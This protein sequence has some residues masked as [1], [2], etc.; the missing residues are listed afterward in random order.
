MARKHCTALLALSLLIAGVAGQAAVTKESVQEFVNDVSNKV[1]A[2]KLVSPP[3]AQTMLDQISLSVNSIATA[4]WEIDWAS[5]QSQWDTLVQAANTVVLQIQ[6]I[7]PSIPENS[8][9]T[10]GSIYPRQDME[11]AAAEICDQ[12]AGMKSYAESTY[13]VLLTITSMSA[14]DSILPAEAPTP[15]PAPAVARRMLA[16]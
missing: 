11:D 7:L 12:I 2:V 1:G 15:A 6:M 3:E 13:G 5:Q 9:N 10:W 16:A 4:W 14:C 8:G